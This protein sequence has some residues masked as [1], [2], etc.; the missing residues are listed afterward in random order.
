MANETS[1]KKEAKTVEY[2]VL[3]DCFG[4]Q[5]VGGEDK[6]NRGDG[7]RQDVPDSYYTRH[8]R[9]G[10]RVT[11][12]ADIKV[13]RHFHDTSK[14]TPDEARKAKRHAINAKKVRRITRAEGN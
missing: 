6:K 5:T 10:E 13:S 14:P 9:K 1:E 12:A 8:W 4:F 2:A 11:L 7:R 3:R